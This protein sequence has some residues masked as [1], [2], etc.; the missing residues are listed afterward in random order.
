[1]NICSQHYVGK[2]D[3]NICPDVVLMS[4]TEIE[5][6]ALDPVAELKECLCFSIE[7]VLARLNE[8][9]HED[10]D[11]IDYLCVQLARI[12]NLVERA[13]DLYDI[14]DGIVHSLKLAKEK[15]KSLGGV[16]DQTQTVFVFSGCRGRPSVYIPKDLL[17]LYVNYKF[18]LKKIGEIFGVSRKTIQRR[19]SEFGLGLRSYA[20][21]SN[22]QLDEQMQVI[23]N[24][25]SGGNTH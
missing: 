7:N 21:L 10:V 4:L 13:S 2:Q 3:N 8:R 12:E 6:H 9:I 5:E 17:Q 18:T 16:N 1:M 11:G 14:P 25:P 20:E 19:I 24:Y 23:H 22:E 15:L